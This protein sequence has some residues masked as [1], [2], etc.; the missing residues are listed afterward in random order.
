[1]RRA[2]RPVV[3]LPFDNFVLRHLTSEAIAG[4]PKRH[5]A[6]LEPDSHAG[7]SFSEKMTFALAAI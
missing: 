3:Y 6:K 5:N 2:S 4:D 7:S 1:M